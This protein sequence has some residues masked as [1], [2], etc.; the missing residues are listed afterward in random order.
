MTSLR[1]QLLVSLLAALSA[2]LMAAAYASYRLAREEADESFDYQLRQIALAQRRGDF[3]NVVAPG[4]PEEDVDFVVQVF[5]AD[6][7]R[8]YL[9]DARSALPR[10]QHPGFDYLQFGNEAWRVYADKHHGKLIEVAQP[11][12]DREELATTAALR[13]VA[14]FLVLLPLVAIMVW[15]IVGRGLASLSRL[16]LLVSDRSSED[17]TPLPLQDAPREVLPLIHALNSLLARLGKSL[18]SQR[19]FVAD[20]AHELRTPLTA[21]TL[22]AQ[23]IERANDNAGRNEALADLKAGLHRATH[24]VAQLLTLARSEPG[25]DGQ[26]FHR[27]NLSELAR[28]VSSRY[29]TLAEAHG[30]DLGIAAENN[31]AVIAGET[32]ALEVLLANLLEN[33]IRYT[34]RGGRIDIATGIEATSAWLEVADTGP[35]IPVEERE[36]VFDRFYRQSGTDGSGTGLGLA[37]V[38]AIAERHGAKV[39]LAGVPTGGLKVKVSFS[40]YHGSASTEPSSR[41]L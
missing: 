20:A 22:Q 15:L 7:A 33:A 12:S 21:L 27:V 5:A 4:D 36:R 32:V 3:H 34:P 35:G 25:G 11:L 38:K 30:L 6:G 37:I 39:M 29:L 18:E 1:R 14:P 10:P 13:A 8:V 16:A 40:R 26:R 23:L 28:A 31:Q 41:V 2:A 9:S 17:L 24:V 19:S